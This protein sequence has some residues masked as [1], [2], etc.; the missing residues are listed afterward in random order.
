MQL[1]HTKMIGKTNIELKMSFHD[2]EANKKGLFTSKTTIIVHVNYSPH[3]LFE[4]ERWGIG[5][6]VGIGVTCVPEW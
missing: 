1:K 4:R 2:R 5:K 6:R 3:P